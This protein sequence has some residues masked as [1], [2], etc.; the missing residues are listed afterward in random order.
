MST[1][2]SEVIVWQNCLECVESATVRRSWAREFLR[3]EPA[4]T[5]GLDA[6][7]RVLVTMIV[8]HFG[9]QPTGTGERFVFALE[10]NLCDDETGAGP[11]EDIDFP[12]V[13]VE[14][15]SVA[16]LLDD[17]GAAQ[18]EQ[19]FGVFVWNRVLEL[20]GRESPGS[21]LDRE[22]GL[23]VGDADA[24]DDVRGVCEVALADRGR[25]GAFTPT[26][27]THEEFSFNLDR[28]FLDLDLGLIAHR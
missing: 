24:D 17:F 6:E 13:S 8:G 14:F 12:Y 27:T 18:L 3:V 10:F 9:P 5:K 28:D 1:W 4:G 20:W 19:V 11:G 21:A 25:A 23:E 16:N 2:Q 7:S 22:G 15:D 26:V